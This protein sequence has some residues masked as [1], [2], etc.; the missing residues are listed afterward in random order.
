MIPSAEVIAIV[1]SLTALSE[2]PAPLRST[3]A[4]LRL[5]LVLSFAS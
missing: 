4:M 3:P 5:A 1:A 2:A